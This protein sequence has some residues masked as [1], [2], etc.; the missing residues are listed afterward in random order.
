MKTKPR[1]TILLLTILTLSSIWTLLLSNA[2]V[3]PEVSGGGTY[4]SDYGLL[5]SDTYLLYLWEH[6]SIQTS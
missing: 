4:Y 5:D 6:E 3:P 2:V 1:F